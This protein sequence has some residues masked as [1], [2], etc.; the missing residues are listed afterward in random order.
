MNNRKVYEYAILR[1]VPKVEREEFINVGVLL[2]S[3]HLRFIGIK[4]ILPTEKL[5]MLD[6]LL[7][8]TI[9]AEYI[10]GFEAICKGDATIENSVSAMEPAERFRWL[11][12]NRS[13][14]IQTSCIHT[15][16][17]DN[18]QQTLED[19]FSKYVL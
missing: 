15:G 14:M 18:A 13:S 9:V 3:R 8:T 7:D 10:K 19:L 16:L 5:L 1:V 4:T 6:P 2:F 17:T 11:T 12:A